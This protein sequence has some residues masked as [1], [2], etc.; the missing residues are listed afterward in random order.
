MFFLKMKKE[1]NYMYIDNEKL[2][3]ILKTAQ[4]N[5][6]ND[7]REILDHYINIIEGNAIPKRCI[8]RSLDEIVR[9]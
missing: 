6:K 7:E 5:N 2:I 9:N 8:W 3:N 1:L 4:S